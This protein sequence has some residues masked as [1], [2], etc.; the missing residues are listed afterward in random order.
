MP[1]YSIAFALLLTA[2]TLLLGV[3]FLPFLLLPRRCFKWPRL[4]WLSGVLLLVRRV[5]G[6]TWQ[7]TGTQ[8]TGVFILAAQ[9]Q[10]ALETFIIARLYP[11]AAFVLKRELLWI[12][13]FG[14]Y[15]WKTQTISL[16]RKAGVTALR[17][18]A[19]AA[20]KSQRVLIIF[21]QGTRQAPNT[22]VRVLPGVALLAEQTGLPV[23]PLTLNT[24]L[25][26]PKNMAKAQRGMASLHF[27]E[28]YPA[29]MP[30]RALV[31]T[32]AALYT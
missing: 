32:L 24:G 21:P 23:I 12:P 13:I 11:D 27:H 19:D 6:I 7:L 16:N 1:F 29:A 22:A 5:L 4:L 14:W 3:L 15:L 18:L 20:K 9:H 2:W 31:N 25:F 30:R 17:R 10:S 26:W 28:A 8:P